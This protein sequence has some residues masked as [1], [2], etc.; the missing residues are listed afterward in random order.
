MVERKNQDEFPPGSPEAIKAGCKCPI[1]D[2]CYGK[3][4][5]MEDGVP[6]FWIIEN[7]P[8]HTESKE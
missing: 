1:L 8:L 6:Q 2:N 7:C 5:F 4:A 3:G